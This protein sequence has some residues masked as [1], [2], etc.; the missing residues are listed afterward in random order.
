MTR[1]AFVCC[2]LGILFTLRADDAEASLDL[3]VS[4][5]ELTRWSSAVVVGTSIESNSVWEGTHIVTFSRVRVERLVVGRMAIAQP[6][7]KTLGGTVGEIGQIVGGEAELPPGTRWMLFLRE[8]PDG[9]LSVTARAQG[10]FRVA[11][12]QAGEAILAPSPHVARLLARRGYV[13]TRFAA[14]ELQGQ[15]L[16]TAERTIRV[17]WEQTHAP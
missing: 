7:V 13:S 12:G 4:V 3:G 11:E 17:T 8:S 5:G 1:K 9:T 14:S 10:Q 6:I 2:C 16:E 15:S